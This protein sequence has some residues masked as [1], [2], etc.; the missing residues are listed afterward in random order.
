MLVYATVLSGGLVAGLNAGAQFNT[1]PLMAGQWIP[2]GLYYM[3]PWYT[4]VFE[5]MMTIQFNHRYLAMTTA[6]IVIFFFIWNRNINIGK[7]GSFARYA[8]LFMV[9]AQVSLGIMTLLSAAWLPLASLHQTGAIVLLTTVIWTTHE[10]CYAQ[11]AVPTSK[12]TQT[13]AK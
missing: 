2:D 4:N 8:M 10:I 7:S 9:L 6:L 1:F 12:K 13:S 11:N 3:E 5:N